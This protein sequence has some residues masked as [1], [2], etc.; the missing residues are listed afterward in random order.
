MGL[1]LGSG[2]SLGLGLDWRSGWRSG[3]RLGLETR[4]E[5]QRAQHNALT[6]TAEIEARLDSSSERYLVVLVCSSE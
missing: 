2:L 4:S 3:W 6:S 1:G 5:H